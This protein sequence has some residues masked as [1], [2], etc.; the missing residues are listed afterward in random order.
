MV[1]A[2]DRF[3][4]FGDVSHGPA[5]ALAAAA[6]A[7]VFGSGSA[8]AALIAVAGNVADNGVS[9]L[10]ANAAAVGGNPGAA[11]ARVGRG[12]AGGLTLVIPFQLPTLAP[13]EA[14][15]SADFSAFFLSELDTAN[16]TYNTD[17]FVITPRTTATVQ[18]GDYSGGTLIGDNF[19]TNAVDTTNNN[20]N[21]TNQRISTS[22][23]ADA[24]LT[25]YLNNLYATDPAAAG[26]FVFFRLAPD[27]TGNIGGGSF[28]GYIF[29]TSNAVDANR[30][31][32]L[33][34]DVPEPAS[35]TLATLGL[36]MIAGRRRR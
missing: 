35:V 30:R 22:A 28:D 21:D 5:R 32:L 36:A 10:N 17:L 20:L 16:P 25:T 11:D 14:I 1:R 15:I 8:S 18:A 26:K 27:V 19:L 34:L 23:A 31:P 4:A 12:S 13:G 9:K 33:T 6:I 24:L 2:S 29:A 3:P 7:A